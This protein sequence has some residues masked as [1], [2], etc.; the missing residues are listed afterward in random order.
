M[1]I[2]GETRVI[3]ETLDQTYVRLRPLFDKLKE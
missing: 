1:P 2:I 3:P